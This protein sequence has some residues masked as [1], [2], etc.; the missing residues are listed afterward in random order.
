MVACNCTP[1][2]FKNASG[3]L[4]C[5][6][7]K[8]VKCKIASNVSCPGYERVPRKQDRL[9]PPPA[10]PPSPATSSASPLCLCQG[11]IKLSQ[12]KKCRYIGP[13]ISISLIWINASNG[14]IYVADA[15]SLTRSQLLRYT[16]IQ[17][18]PRKGHTHTHKE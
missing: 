16:L 9:K 4:N 2:P 18:D 11:W 10:T 1:P 15:W 17:A 5:Q 6:L 13:E 7:L 8:W 14:N 3:N 12:Q